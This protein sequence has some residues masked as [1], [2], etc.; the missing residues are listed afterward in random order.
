ML[1]SVLPCPSP[2]RARPGDAR[3]SSPDRRVCPECSGPI[4]RAS[5]CV[6]CAHCGWA[7]CG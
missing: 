2:G 6:H 4:V 1:I 5:G 3:F 7:R